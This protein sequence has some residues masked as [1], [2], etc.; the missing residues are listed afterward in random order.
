MSRRI[1][2]FSFL[3]F[4][5]WL[6]PA[7]RY[8]TAAE[9]NTPTRLDKAHQSYKEAN[10]EKAKEIYQTLLE[11]YP[12]SAGL[13]YDLGNVYFKLKKIG[14]SILEYE[15]ARRIKPRDYEINKNLA[16][17]QGLIEYKVEDK[18]NWYLVQ[19]HKLLGM[20]SWR[21]VMFLA[22]GFYL[23]FISFLTLRYFLRRKGPFLKLVN[24]FFI[25]FLLSCPFLMSKY[26]EEK[27]YRD[28]VVV[29]PQS[30]VRYGPSLSDKVAFRLVEGLRVRVQEERDD[31]YLVG[32]VSGES[33]WS[34]KKNLEVI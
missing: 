21:E 7:V 2:F 12:G 14:Y 11:D 4:F 10:F 9:Q 20:F 34:E 19:W 32:L 30:E 1:G 23:F 8:L 33:G 15:R 17:V 13:H 16:Y 6:F 25:L 18:R 31:W 29:S 27:F 28:A 3:F 26:M 24:L 5:A 22:S